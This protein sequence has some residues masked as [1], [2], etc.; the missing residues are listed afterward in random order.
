MLIWF[1][2]YI[3]YWGNP[4]ELTKMTREIKTQEEFRS[5]CE[6]IAYYAVQRIRAKGSIITCEEFRQTVSAYKTICGGIWNCANPDTCEYE[7]ISECEDVFFDNL[8]RGPTE[9]EFKRLG[10]GIMFIVG[11]ENNDGGM[12]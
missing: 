12:Y 8:V 3:P 6:K 10:E 11:T 4:K 9:E 2:W 7:T 1:V 5:E